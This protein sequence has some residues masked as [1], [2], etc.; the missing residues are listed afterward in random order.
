MH[1]EQSGYDTHSDMLNRLDKQT[2]ELDAAVDAFVTEMKEQHLW[3]DITVV[4]ATGKKS[5]IERTFFIKLWNKF[6]MSETSQYL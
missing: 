5:D 3:D 6:K 2:L 1:S 4:V